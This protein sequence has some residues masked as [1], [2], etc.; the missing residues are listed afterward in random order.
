MEAELNTTSQAR[1]AFWFSLALGITASF[2]LLYLIYQV[3]TT[4]I[5]LVW[6]VYA[7]LAAIGLFS[8]AAWASTWL[9]YRQRHESG[10]TILLSGLMLLVLILPFVVTNR[11][12][13]VSILAVLLTI[14]LT[15]QTLPDKQTNWWIS[16]SAV[17]GIT[18]VLLDLWIPLER[19]ST[20]YSP[21][22][23]FALILLAGAFLIVLLAQFRRLRLRTKLMVVFTAIPAVIVLLV[24]GFFLLSFVNS[25][26]AQFM[27]NNA[28]DAEKKVENMT[29]FLAGVSSDVQ[30]LSQTA[31]LENYLSTLAAGDDAATAAARRELNAEFLAFAQARNIYDQVRY[32][33]A[34]GQEIVRVNTDRNGVSAI[35]PSED[36]Q[37]KA[38]R[39]YF[40]DTM[41]Q[42]PGELMI[43]PLDLNVENNEIEVPHKP[44]IRYGLPV[45]YKGERV[46]VIILNVLAERFLDE[47]A[48]EN[49]TDILVDANGYY[50][51]HPEES[52]RW[53]GDLGTGFSIFQDSP[54]LADR[55]FSGPATAGTFTDSAYQYIYLPVVIPGQESPSWFLVNQLARDKALATVNETLKVGQ[56]VLVISLM[57]TPLL[58]LLFSQA[59][60]RPVSALAQSAQ[61]ITQG[62]LDV[63]VKVYSQDEFGLLAQTFNG[64]VRRLKEAFS[65]LESRV[66]DRTRDLALAAELGRNLSQVYD[67]DVLLQTA[68]DL[69]HERFDLYYT[70]IYLPNETQQILVLRAGTGEVGQRLRQARHTLPLGPGS[71][72]GTAAAEKVPVI[73]ADTAKDARFQANSLLPFTRSEMAIPMLIGERVVGVLNLQSDQP[74]ELTEENLPAFV[75]L[76][77]QLAIAIENATLFTETLEARREIENYTRRITRA[78][79]ENYL[80]GIERPST[81][82]YVFN[83]ETDSVQA[84]A[85][86]EN[87][88]GADLAA[89]IAIVNE[90]VGSIQI[91]LEDDQPWTED[92]LILLQMVAKEVGQQIENLRL[93]EDA[94]HYQAE[95]EKALRRLTQEAWQTTQ[96]KT[97][98]IDTLVYDQKQVHQLPAAELPEA[99][100]IT[101][102]M[103]IHNEVIGE[104]SIAAVSGMDETEAAEITAVVAEQLSRH[105]ESLRL[106]EATELALGEA[107]RRSRELAV[108]NRVVNK[109]SAVNGLRESMQV[110]VDEIAEAIQVDQVRVAI[111]DEQGSHLVVIAEHYDETKAP[112]AVGQQIPVVGNKLTEQVIQSRQSCFI[113]DA[114]TSPL[115]LPI[116]EML[117]TQGILSLAILPIIISGAVVGTIGLDILDPDKTIGTEQLQLAE[118]IVL[119]AATAIEKARLF[120]QTE[121]RAEELAVINEVAQVVAQQIDQQGLLLTVYEQI[122]RVM[123][124]DACFVALHNQALNLVEYP[125]VYDNG[126]IYHETP[127]PYRKGSNIARVIETGEPLLINRTAEEIHNIILGQQASMIGD[128]QKPSASLLYVPLR[129]GQ[130][131]M[132]VLSIHSYSLNAYS[133]SN[134][135]L[136]SGIA[137]H[138]AVALDNARLLAESRRAAQRAQ[139]LREISGSVNATMDAESI[140]QTAAREIGRALGL[141][142]YVYLQNPDANGHQHTPQ[143][144]AAEQQQA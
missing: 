92:D 53:G 109:I 16:I 84:E 122:R 85:A 3:V 37:N 87:G 72:N 83:G 81:L 24:G 78:G 126:R 4:E 42:P 93:L 10:V 91:E 141:Q 89:P 111:I 95:A 6:Q 137:N 60:T 113:A 108:L 25:L 144:E 86:P 67:L 105:L 103:R 23:L 119:Q 32:L 21:L 139:L 120:E 35:V 1:K 117:Q 143:P 131:I 79:W 46:G 73:V 9:S 99:A 98:L 49:N 88:L 64:M 44:V 101:Q 22:P 2:G 31:V 40:D 100:A 52:K 14:S 140:L 125:F 112:S 30:F 26:N 128:Q 45:T 29:S 27:Q 58:S 121:A 15:T 54:E 55:L 20:Q 136:L 82:N 132:G 34:T 123:P 107:Q 33:D 68:V 50:L 12:V 110:I 41:A 70:Q 77:G 18:S 138:V 51:Y 71:I 13:P 130:E 80:D 7:G 96:D 66:S 127:G 57:L 39:Y 63:E 48:D 118:A 36:L 115:T 62:N 102:P 74:N 69:I 142:T 47:L 61:E 129:I 135:A 114:S 56:A 106:A 65:L 90:P 134:T 5:I 97:E 75:A 28:V 104:L 38:G 76:A 94:S 116:R 8:L 59:I 17:A 133:Q 124:V 19:I 11:S 43:S